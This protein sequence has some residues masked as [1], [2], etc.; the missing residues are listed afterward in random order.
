MTEYEGGEPRPFG[1]IRDA[2]FL[3]LINK[4]LFHPRGFALAFIKDEDGNFKGWTILGDGTECWSFSEAI[5]DEYFGKAERELAQ[6]AELNKNKPR[7][8]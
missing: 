1:D 8:Q 2:G 7:R 6:Y 4:A 5:D 3:W